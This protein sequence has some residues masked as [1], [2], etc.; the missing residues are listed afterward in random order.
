MKGTLD[1]PN[2]S[3]VVDVVVIKADSTE[4]AIII[5]PRSS[6]YRVNCY[7]VNTASGIGDTFPDIVISSTDETGR[8]SGTVSTPT[9]TKAGTIGNSTIP[10]RCL[11]GSSIAYT[12]SGGAYTNGLTFNL[13]F[14]IE[15]I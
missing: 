13:H 8:G 6:M 7:I 9:D 10:V 3:A 11:A 4:Q 14:V 12:I 1:G 2:D 15:S 5:A